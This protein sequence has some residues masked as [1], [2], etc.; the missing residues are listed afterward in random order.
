MTNSILPK[1]IKLS[2]FLVDEL[3]PSNISI[4]LHSLEMELETPSTILFQNAFL[5]TSGTE[6]ASGENAS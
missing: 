1:F 3:K 4:N 5:N 2:S 6:G